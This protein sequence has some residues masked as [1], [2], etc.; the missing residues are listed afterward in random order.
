LARLIAAAHRRETAVVSESA[1]LDALRRVAGR[2]LICRGI[3]T[4]D[5]LAEEV[6]HAVNARI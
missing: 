5:A 2:R 4:P 6:G 3:A 1:G